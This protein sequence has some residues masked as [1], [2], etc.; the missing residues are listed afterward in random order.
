[1]EQLKDEALRREYE[2]LYQMSIEGNTNAIEEFVKSKTKTYL[3][4]FCK[5]NY[6]PVYSASKNRIT[7][8][9]IRWMRQRNAIQKKLKG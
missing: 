6:L 9:I 1:M 5:A 7:K 4:A 8:E 2:N 3:K